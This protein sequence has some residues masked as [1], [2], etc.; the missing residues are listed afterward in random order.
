MASGWPVDLTPVA[1]IA[2]AWAMGTIPCSV[3][4]TRLLA[5]ADPRSVADGN[6]G[7]TNAFR[8]GGRAAGLLSAF[9]DVSKAAAPAFAAAIL[10]GVPGW[11]LVPFIAAP[12]VGHCWSP[13]LRFRGGKGVAPAYGTLMPVT[14]PWGIPLLPLAL[15]LAYKTIA[16][17]GWAPVLGSSLAVVLLLAA[18]ALPAAVGAAVVVA[19]IVL[20]YRD[21]LRQGIAIRRRVAGPAA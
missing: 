14:F 7:A 17:D 21:D 8:A 4:V 15:V 3:I 16:P 6:P 5:G 13:W 20:R 9:L 18:G 11:W 1:W 12:V 2:L 19:I 10:G